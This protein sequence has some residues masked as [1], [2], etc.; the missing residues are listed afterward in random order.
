MNRTRI[1]IVVWL[2]AWI[3]LSI[4]AG[5]YTNVNAQNITDSPMARDLTA[6][7]AQWWAD[8]G[9]TVPPYTVIRAPINGGLGYTDIANHVVYINTDTWNQAQ[10]WPLTYLLQDRRN[11]LCK[12]WIHETGHIIGL[13]HWPAPSVMAPDIG[14]IPT[15]GTCNRF[16]RGEP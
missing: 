7:A 10:G 12:T 2:T 15:I 3:Y 4:L 6:R 5:G 13:G 9:R 1:A 8:N 16:A 14:G 11:T